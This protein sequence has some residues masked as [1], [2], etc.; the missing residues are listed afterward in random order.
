MIRRNLLPL[1]LLAVP[2]GRLVAAILGWA[3]TCPCCGTLRDV[4]FGGPDVCYDQ[5][6]GD[7]VRDANHD[8]VVDMHDIAMFQQ[9]FPDH[10][11]DLQRDLW[12][13][14]WPTLNDDWSVR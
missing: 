6:G 14:G 8:G 12:S 11:F 5:E 10:P 7:W 4:E 3:V 9:A 1:L 13:G 2:W